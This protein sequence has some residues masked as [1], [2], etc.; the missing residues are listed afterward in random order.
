MRVTVRSYSFYIIA[1]AFI[2]S[3]CLLSACGNSDAEVFGQNEKKETREEAYKVES[4]MSQEGT[5]KAKLTAP[6]MYRYTADSLFVEFPKSLH[7]DFYDDSA[8]IETYLDARYAKYFESQSKVYLRDSV[9][10]ITLKGDT[11]RCHDLW[12]DQN[13]GTFYTNKYAE[14]RAKSQ[15]IQGGQGLEATQDLKT[16]S[17]LGPTGVVEYE[18]SQFGQ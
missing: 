14:Y 16:V 12:W 10:V 3:C 1:A 15:N 18:N 13:R 11:L 4:Y 6:V 5:M 17:F 7:V 8:A 9:V 2:G